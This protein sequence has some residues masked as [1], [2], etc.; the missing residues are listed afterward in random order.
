MWLALAA[1]LHRGNAQRLPAEF[2]NTAAFVSPAP[3]TL[4]NA[5]TDIL[6]GPSLQNLDPS[7]AKTFRTASFGRITLKLLF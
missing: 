6:V 1:Q 2:F 4:G 5:Q 7:L 3:F